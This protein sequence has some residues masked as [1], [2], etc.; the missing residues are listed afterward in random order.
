MQ[1]FCNKFT[2]FQEFLKNLLNIS[3]IVI[4]LVC[5]CVLCQN[6]PM[7]LDKIKNKLK[8]FTTE[9]QE[10]LGTFNGNLVIYDFI[11]FIKNDPSVK[12]IMKDQFTYSESQKEIIVNM[13]DEEFENRLNNKGLFDIENPATWPDKDIF[14]KEHDIASAIIKDFQPFSPIELHLPVQVI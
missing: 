9:Y 1:I 11:E 8:S 4:Y 13:N 10:K 5:I 2:L 3:Q 6:R 7:T 14:A 12:A